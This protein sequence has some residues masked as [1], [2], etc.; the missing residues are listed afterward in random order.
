M[1]GEHY[2]NNSQSFQAKDAFLITLNLNWVEHSCANH[3]IAWLNNERYI[4]MIYMTRL[5]KKKWCR[6]K[7]MIIIKI[8]Y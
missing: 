4:Y 8:V 3:T 6:S 5:D 7:K 2:V 1:L